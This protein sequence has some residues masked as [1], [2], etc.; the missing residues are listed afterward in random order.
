MSIVPPFLL[1]LLVTSLLSFLLPLAVLGAARMSLLLV[2]SIPVLAQL[3]DSGNRSLVEFLATFGSG[4]PVEGVL[5]IGLT[6]SVV[7]SLFDVFVSGRYHLHHL[8]GD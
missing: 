8:R 7:G 6:C 3:G 2:S 4:N 1:S 5:A